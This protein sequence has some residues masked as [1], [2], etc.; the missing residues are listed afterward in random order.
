MANFHTNQLTIAA[1]EGCMLNVLRVMAL[2]LASNAKET[3]YNDLLESATSVGA[4]YKKIWHYIDDWYWLVFTPNPIGSDAW[5]A[6]NPDNAQME[7]QKHPEYATLAQAAANL[8]L[9]KG[10]AAISVSVAPSGRPLSDSADVSMNRF[11]STYVLNVRYETADKSN[12]QDIDCYFRML[13]EGRYGVSFIDADEYDGYEK[14]NVMAGT[15]PGRDG[16][17]AMSGR[18]GKGVNTAQ[19]LADYARANC[20]TDLSKIDDLAVVALM[21]ASAVWP[22]YSSAFE[23]ANDTSSSEAIQAFRDEVN[24]ASH[25]SDHESL[26][27]SCSAGGSRSAFVYI[28]DEYTLKQLDSRIINLLTR[29][30]FECEITG[31][32]YEGRNEKIEYLVPGA[33]LRLESD[34]DSPYF[35]Y[36][37]IGIY[38]T[39]GRSLGNLGG[40]FNPTDEDRVAIACL[41]PHIKATAVDVSPL[42]STLNFRRRIGQFQVHLEIEPIDINAV[43]EEVHQLL[44]E[45][46]SNR[47]R[48]SI[49]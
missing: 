26:D 12:L 40:Y 24:P 18:A 8:G 32:A 28:P 7:L 30:P 6:N 15:H 49:V 33:K 9:G 23:D 34:W 41:L 14:T 22:E 38:D 46:E 42:G 21:H 27:P 43:L 16:F 35:S 48:S 13:P 31:Q 3:S 4:A 37:G 39:S 10:G 25:C 36:A 19:R 5:L 47:V 11:G 44:R 45:Y 2:N 29:F 20:T 1:E 17:S